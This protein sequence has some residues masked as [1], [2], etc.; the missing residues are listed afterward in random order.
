MAPPRRSIF[1]FENV[2]IPEQIEEMRRYEQEMKDRALAESIQRGELMGTEDDDEEIVA[3]PA[4]PQ[5]PNDALVDVDD[6]DESLVDAPIPAPVQTPPPVEIRRSQ[7]NSVVI[8]LTN[9]SPPGPIRNPRSRR[10]P[11]T[12]LTQQP[13]PYIISSR[14]QLASTSQ[15]VSIIDHRVNGDNNEIVAEPQFPSDSSQPSTS[16]GIT[17]SP[18]RIGTPVTTWGECL[19][20]FDSPIE[21]QGCNKCHQ[22]LGCKTCVENWYQSSGCPSCPL[23]RRKWHRKPDVSRMDLVARRRNTKNSRRSQRVHRS[24][25]VAA[26]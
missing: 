6:S 7:R 3:A 13:H 1:I 25:P 14:V 2:D 9:D 26:E 10:S 15:S 19:M 8:D 21:P 4:T 5:V 22:I 17:H 11:L 23:C 12:R 20:C 24:V 18:I 16:R